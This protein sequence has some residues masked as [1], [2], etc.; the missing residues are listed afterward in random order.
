MK[1]V[2]EMG[3]TAESFCAQNAEKLTAQ[4][5]NIP[6]MIMAIFSMPAKYRQ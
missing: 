3:S 1:V 5:I 6:E 4:A 2:L